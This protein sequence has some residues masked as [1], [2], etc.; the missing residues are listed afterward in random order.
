MDLENT[1]KEK[2]LLHYKIR[3]V[4]IK[5]HERLLNKSDSILHISSWLSI[6]NL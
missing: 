6:F 5:Q 1:A 2:K 4:Y 3:Y